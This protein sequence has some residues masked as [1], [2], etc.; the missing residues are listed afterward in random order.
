MHEYLT[1]YL[2]DKIKRLLCFVLGHKWDPCLLGRM[3]KCVRCEFYEDKCK[4][5]DGEK[6]VEDFGLISCSACSVML[7]TKQCDGCGLWFLDWDAEESGDDDVIGRPCVNSSGDLMCSRCVRD[8]QAAEEDD[9][10]DEDYDLEDGT[11][12]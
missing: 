2:I 9:D 8:M 10:D 11:D 7:E 12:Y 4:W 5:H 1:L 3:R 6:G